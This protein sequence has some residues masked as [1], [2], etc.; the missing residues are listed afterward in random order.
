M[1]VGGATATLKVTRQ[2]PAL[3]TVGRVFTLVTIVIVAVAFGIAAV[4]GVGAWAPR[5]EFNS[6]PPA[7]PVD[8]GTIRFESAP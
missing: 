8:D 6:P 7:P 5:I 3:R 2:E 4:V 1:V